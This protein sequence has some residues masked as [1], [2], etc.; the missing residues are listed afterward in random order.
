MS[1]TNGIMTGAVSPDSSQREPGSG[2]FAGEHLVYFYQKT[3]SLLDALCDYVGSALRGDR[4]AIVVG[5]KPHLEGLN[6]RLEARGVDLAS[7]RTNNRYVELDAAETLAKITAGGMPDAARF[8]K[9]IGGIIR[10]SNAAAKGKPPVVFGE[11]VSLLW[12]AGKTDAAVRLEQL[13]N[14]LAKKQSFTL[15]CAYPIADFQGKNSAEPLM[16]ICSEHSTVTLDQEKHS[17]SMI[18]SVALNHS[19]ERFRWL[20]DAVQDY[21]IFMLDTDGVI[22][23][24]NTGA[25]RIKGWAAPEIV[26]K[27]FS[28]FYPQEDIEAGKP[29]RELEIAVRDGSVEDEGW[30]VRKD[31]SRFW[32]SV[33]ISAIRDDAGKLVGF[34]KVTRDFTDRI[35]ANE[36]LRK[37]IADRTE[38]QRRLS[39]SEESLRELSLRLLETQEMERRRIGRDLHDS[40]GQ[41]LVGLKMKL[42]AVKSAADR[43]NQ[44]NVGQLTECSQLAEEAIKEVRTISYLLFPPMLEELGLQSA[45]PWYLEGFTRRSGI[46]TSF[47]VSPAFSRVSQEV[48]L[49][50]FRVLQEGLTNVHRHSDS[51]TAK[52]QLLGQNNRVILKIIDEGK[53]IHPKNWDAT[54]RDGMRAFG[55][56]LR[57]MTERLRQLGG[58]LELSSKPGG[59][60]VTAAIPVT[61]E[62]QAP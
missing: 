10:K 26:G 4:A 43:A 39:E 31:G 36:I 11:M 6:E 28:I 54:A 32:G 13:W 40:V 50:L 53:G 7:A 21:A 8:S 52:V 48:E 55:V 25:Q 46:Q 15:R 3:D 44:D 57:G 22:S 9:I 34:G 23:S 20:V 56:G 49:A 59:T 30:R 61:L 51:A 2:T 41:Y 16:R 29:Q 1:S 5:T 12:A 60:T 42:D 19:E 47:E 14:D 35:R 18:D 33:V 24:W 58:T 17:S 45:I 38:A 62:G 27:H 37:E